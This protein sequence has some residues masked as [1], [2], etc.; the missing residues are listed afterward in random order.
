[1]S[2]FL[3]IIILAQKLAHAPVCT[4]VQSSH[5]AVWWQILHTADQISRFSAESFNPAKPHTKEAQILTLRLDVVLSADASQ[6]WKLGRFDFHPLKP[7]IVIF[8]WKKKQ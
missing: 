6:H 7:S 3:D 8:R 1:M 5:P 4:L 2:S